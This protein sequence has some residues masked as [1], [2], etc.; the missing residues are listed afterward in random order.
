MLRPRQ[1]P[2][3]REQLLRHLDDPA[4]PLRADTGEGMRPGLDAMAHHLRHAELYW[5]ASD[6]AALAMSSGAQLAAARWATAD[7]PSAC[8]LILFDGGIGNV[9]ARGV[10]IPVEACTW[11]PYEGGLLVWTF[12]SRRRLNAEIENVGQVGSDAAPPL[13]PVQGDLLPVTTEPVPMAELEASALPVIQALAASWLLMQQPQL[14]D[15]TRER[16][17]KSAQRNAARNGLSDPEVTVID[18]RRLYA[19]QDADP[20]EGR[21]GGRRYRHRW[22]VSGHWRQQ[23]YGPERSLRRQQWIPAYVKGP[24]GAPL[25][26]TERVNVWRR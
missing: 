18:L 16:P 5:V 15:R 26:A 1:V 4:A 12:M 22:V 7:R 6:M 2:K 24:D 14:V 20:D 9:E 21:E 23:A 3:F 13:V 11:G 19:P 17:D 8:G 25:L 10:N